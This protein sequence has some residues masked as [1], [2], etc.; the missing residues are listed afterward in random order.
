MTPAGLIGPDKLLLASPG[1]YIERR[2]TGREQQ[3]RTMCANL[4][5]PVPT[6]SVT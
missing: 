2:V 1:E 4:E 6:V 3:P 5:V